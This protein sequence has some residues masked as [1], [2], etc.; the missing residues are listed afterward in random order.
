MTI[1][2]TI[3]RGKQLGRT[4]GFP[5]ANI[6]PDAEDMHLERNGVYIARIRVEG[7]DRDMPC[8]VNQGRHPTVPE[9][10]PTIEAHILD[11]ND[12]V[13]D[14]HVELTPLKF[15]REEKKF[16]SLNALKAQL[17]QDLQTTRTYFS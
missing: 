13:Y 3:V 5:T 4:I 9:G 16:E 7:Y 2:G 17:Q 12:D 11:F 1:T 8:M 14:L 10:A 15:I 6:R